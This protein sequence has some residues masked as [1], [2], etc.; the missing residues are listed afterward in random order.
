MI[1]FLTTRGHTHT[2]GGYLQSPR[3]RARIE[4]K[5]YDWLFSR[6]SVRAGTFVF[7][8]LERLAHHELAAA[9]RAFRLFEKAGLRT[10]NDPAWVQARVGLLHKLQVE[11]INDFRCYHAELEPRPERFPVFIRG[12]S[13]HGKPHGGLIAD[14]MTLDRELIRLREAGIPL[15]GLLVIEFSAAPIRDGAYRKHSVFRVADELLSFTPVIEDSWYVKY[16]KTGF[17]SDDELAACTREMDD[18]P[19]AERLRPVFELARIEYGRVDFGV[20][21]DRISV[22]EINTNPSVALPSPHRHVDYERATRA[23]IDRITDAVC[24]QD[25]GD[26]SDIPTPWKEVSRLRLGRFLRRP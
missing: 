24:N 25:S 22:F 17:S 18:N 1:T 6:R 9:A 13:N 8:D 20:V 19:F 23:S 12:E 2:I 21:D 5:T 11:G 10:L 16:G 14:Q 3:R 7:T 26:G 4:V 15:R